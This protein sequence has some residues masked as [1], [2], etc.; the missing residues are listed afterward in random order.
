MSHKTK[1]CH[2]KGVSLKT[3]PFHFLLFQHIL[4]NSLATYMLESWDL[5]HSKGEIHSSVWST[6]TFLYDIREPRKK[7]IK[8]G[9]HISKFLNIGQS[10]FLKSDVPY[11]FNYIQAPLCFIEMGLNLPNDV[12]F[13]W[14]M[15]QTT[16]M[17]IAREIIRESWP[18][19]I[20]RYFQIVHYS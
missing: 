13:K 20:S 2:I 10:S 17:F 19:Q 4:F 1:L 9:Y 16:K 11:C 8:M 15:S 5:Y 3:W 12:T 7:K 18:C 14:I 6:K